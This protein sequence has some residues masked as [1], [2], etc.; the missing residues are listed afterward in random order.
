MDWRE[1]PRQKRMAIGSADG[2]A[3]S[4]RAITMLTGV[5]RRFVTSGAAIR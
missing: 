3:R 1:A 5:V 2:S 4:V